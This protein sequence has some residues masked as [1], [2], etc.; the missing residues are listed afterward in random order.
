[1]DANLDLMTAPAIGQGDDSVSI[2][3]TPSAIDAAEAPADLQT[4]AMTQ[5]SAEAASY[6][7]INGAEGRY[8]AISG[9]LQRSGGYSIEIVSTQLVDGTWVI[10]A[11]VVPPTG[12]A[13][14]ALTNPVGYFQLGGMEGNV[15]V[16]INGAAL[17]TEKR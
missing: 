7:V 10:E 4:W 5:K 6:S 11:Q 8:L 17:Q 3:I 2:Q 9:G 16:Q 14:M 12:P 15:E 1:A 13:T